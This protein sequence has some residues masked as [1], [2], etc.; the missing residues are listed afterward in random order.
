MPVSLLGLRS[1]RVFTVLVKKTILHL[2]LMENSTVGG[3]GFR[4]LMI[5]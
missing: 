5:R 1:F 4:L 3:N 2:R